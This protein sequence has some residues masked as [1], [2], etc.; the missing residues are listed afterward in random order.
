VLTGSKR[1]RPAL[2]KGTAAVKAASGSLK[3]IMGL[4]AAVLAVCLCTLAVV[5]RRG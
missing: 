5:A 4:L 3:I 2:E 1:L